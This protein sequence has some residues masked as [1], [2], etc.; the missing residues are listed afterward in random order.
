MPYFNNGSSEEKQLYKLSKTEYNLE[1]ILTNSKYDM[2]MP[3]F[4]KLNR[5]QYFF[6]HA[7][8]LCIVVS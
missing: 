5:C 3:F 1:N 2:T 7:G 4:F 8:E 6:E